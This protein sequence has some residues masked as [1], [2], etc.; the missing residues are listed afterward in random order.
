M[1]RRQRSERGFTLVELLVTISIIGVL[2]ALL[3][4]AVNMARGASRSITCMNNLRQFGVGLQSR[5]GQHN[6]FTSGA[7]D[8]EYDGVVTE[9]GWVSDLVAQT[10]PVGQMLCPTN[11]ARVS[12]SVNQM[13]ELAES[14]FSGCVDP[15]G[16]QP[17]TLPDGTP[18]INPCRK[19]LDESLDPLSAERV[20]VVESLMIERFYNTNYVASWL[21]VRSRPRL[22]RGGNPE[23]KNPA[24]VAS[25][26]AVEST[27]GPLSLSV[28]DTAKVPSNTIPLLA[29][30]AVDQL[31]KADVGEF[32]AGEGTAGR[33]T[34]GP[35]QT[36]TL[37][38]PTF[39]DGKPRN[40]AGGWWA[41]WDKTRQDYRGFAPLHR[42]ACNVLMADGGVHTFVDTNG[43][44]Y[45]NNG[46][47]ASAESGFTD[48]EEEV[49]DATLFSK[50]ALGRI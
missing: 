19:I 40:G 22:D 39:D 16:S 43:D 21:M 12:S 17:S 1:S 5:A 25:L 46:F 6:T 7:T 20:A 37:K 28:L 24:C 41:V 15:R 38:A 2:V 30:S 35:V 47:P 33:F 23:S 26:K 42:G 14:D 4:P 8:W 10:I 45:I 49:S 3:I 31:L 18:V 48:D 13:L 50:A 27:Y 36:L 9:V 29:D 11:E 34:R 44:G 32:Q